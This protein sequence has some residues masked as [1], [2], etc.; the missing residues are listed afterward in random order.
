MM[1]TE[2]R[3]GFTDCA[4]CRDGKDVRLSVELTDIALAI[5]LLRDCSDR[6][7]SICETIAVRIDA[8]A[9]ELLEV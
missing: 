1:C 8:I 2:H 7:E 9:K 5:R 6:S 3:G 4:K